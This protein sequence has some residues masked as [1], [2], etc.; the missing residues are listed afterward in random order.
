MGGLKVV[1][2]KP[3]LSDWVG[4]TFPW[5]RSRLLNSRVLVV[6]DLGKPARAG[7]PDSPLLSV[8]LAR[9][10]MSPLA[11]RAAKRALSREI[12]EG[13]LDRTFEFARDLSAKVGLV[14]AS[15]L[16]LFALVGAILPF[17]GRSIMFNL[18]ASPPV[19]DI[20][21]VVTVWLLYSFMP[22]LLAYMLWPIAGSTLH[23]IHLGAAEIHM[24]DRDGRIT[25]IPL[26]DVAAAMSRLSGWR[27]TTR[28]S[29]KFF[30]P[31]VPGLSFVLQAVAVRLD[32]S[33]PD[34]ERRSLRRTLAR[35]AV[36]W[37][38]G[39]I[40]AGILA[41]F[42]GGAPQTLVANPLLNTALYIALTAAVPIA[43]L[44]VGL[45]LIERS[46]RTLFRFLERRGRA[47][48]RRRPQP[49]PAAL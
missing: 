34:K 26:A 19:L 27:I 21:L 4:K 38:L 31:N 43:Y 3:P 44:S 8:W 14:I 9:E 36:L 39:S 18:G 10:S 33:L 1:S 12:D 24:T 20:A 17:F 49:R 30:L 15:S 47:R 40:A 28:D 25:Q 7:A 22:T 29:R 35:A 32:P 5:S 37:I 46:A 11:A 48:A 13:R 45:P 6:D 23:R 42:N 41:H 16:A 2:A